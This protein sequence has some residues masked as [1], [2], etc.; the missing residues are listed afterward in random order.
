MIRM[1]IIMAD[2]DELYLS[3][4]CAYLMEKSSQMDLNLFTQEDKLLQALEKGERAD[5]LIIDEKMASAA[6]LEL[7]Q[8]MT[9]IAL[10]S[11]YTDVAGFSLVRKYQKSE[12]LLNE[13][14]LKHAENNGSVEAIVGKSNTKLI[15]FYSPAGGSGKTVLALATAAVAAKRGYKSFYLNLE[16]IDSVQETLL[17]TAGNL[18]ELYLA[19]KTK[20][21]NEGVRLAAGIGQD[22]DGEFYYISGVDSISTYEEVDGEDMVQLLETVRGLSEYD[23]VI[24]DMASS[25]DARTRKILEKVDNILVPVVAEEASVTKLK[26]FLGETQYHDMYNGMIKK[27]SLVINQVGDNGIDNLLHGSGLLNELP[28]CAAIA[29]SSIFSNYREMLKGGDSLELVIE[30]ILQMVLNQ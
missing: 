10:V 21:M 19:L 25:F 28:C 1:K 30:P 17:K 11:E 2:R 16:E 29:R 24:I 9:R 18:S 5:I 12:T 26:R 6:L 14:L 15:S 23:I 4:L 8:N 13:I 27:M 7:T 22:R 3:S 20:G